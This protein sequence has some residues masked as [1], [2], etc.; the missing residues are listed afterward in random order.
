MAR[1]PADPSERRARLRLVTPDDPP[2]A[3]RSWF[4]EHW[5]DSLIGAGLAAAVGLLGWGILVSALAD[6]RS[7]D[8][9][10][11]AL[12]IRPDDSQA[13]A[14]LA[15]RRMAS[16]DIATAQSL[17]RRAIVADPMEL[18]AF[19][20]LAQAAAAEGRAPKADELM[21]IAGRRAKRDRPAQLWLLQRRAAQGRFDDA[22]AHADG[23]LRAWPIEMRGPV[24]RL[25]SAMAVDPDAGKAIAADLA[26]DPPWRTRF[27][28]DL[29]RG[30]SDLAAPFTVFSAL[31][32]SKQPPRDL[33][34]QAY[35]DRLVREGLFQAAYVTWV[36]LLPPKGMNGLGDLYDGGF[37]GLP[38]PPPF[39]WQIPRIKGGSIRLDPGPG[40]SGGGA[41]HLSF[42]GGPAPVV[43]TRQLLVL[44]PGRYR[45]LG[46]ARAD[47]LDSALGLIWTVRCAEG[48][49]QAA[50]QTGRVLET[51]GW[52]PI[53]AEF[54]VRP[55]A[56]SAQWLTLEQAAGRPIATRGEVWFD[57]LQILRA[58]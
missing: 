9:P 33:E 57:D 29:S 42:G 36:Q 12:R 53:A 34:L 52:A 8:Q 23:L 32:D 10:E 45:L 5:R 47:R 17:A 15:D 16:G 1:G 43:L 46:Q 26:T 28:I 30:T 38:G 27:L 37:D 41:L 44:P 3:P 40:G 11:A 55:G 7:A 18:T 48:S 13:L 25:L 14:S 49:R 50:G 22:V 56:C 24:T 19:R 20:T 35:I 54:E 21:T 51:A 39:N 58:N 6:Q 4:R 31:Q 2:P